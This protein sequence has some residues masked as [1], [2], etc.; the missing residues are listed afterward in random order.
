MATNKTRTAPTW[1][2]V[3]AKLA[4]FD[5]AGLVGL[6]SDLHS[7]SR[8]NQAF[9]HA[10]LG[11]G[12]DP[13]APYKAT[14]SQWI[15]PDLIRGQVISVAKAKK[16]ISDYKKAIGLPAGVAEL[17]VF[18]CESAA[19]LLSECGMEDEGHFTALVRMFDQ[20]LTAVAKLS[21]SERRALLQLLD[22]VRSA[23]NV[24]GW[25]VKDAMDELWVEQVW[26]D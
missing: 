8:D 18:Y 16:A 11:L 21:S 17:S 10:R 23:T 6:L 3:K 19:R 24:V 2:E 20:A 12:P 13:L 22:A 5:R 4:L 26:E 1:S 14:I 7:L 9:L 15:Y 25:G